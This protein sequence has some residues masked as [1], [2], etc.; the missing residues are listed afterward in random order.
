MSLA[1]RDPQDAPPTKA[2]NPDAQSTS[3]PSDI[4][5]ADL[6]RELQETNRLLRAIVSQKAVGLESLKVLPTLPT[7]PSPTAVGGGA[8][9]SPSPPELQATRAQARLLVETLA[10]AAFDPADREHLKLFREETIQLVTKT[11]ELRG[12]DGRDGFDIVPRSQVGVVLRLQDQLDHNIDSPSELL[13]SCRTHDAERNPRLTDHE[14]EQLRRQWPVYFDLDRLTQG[15]ARDSGWI[16]GNNPR[17][18]GVLCAS[19]LVVGPNH[20]LV[21]ASTILEP[22]QADALAV[23]RISSSN[24]VS[25]GSL[26]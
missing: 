4:S 19:P 10:R 7:V 6:A 20:D 15:I 12:H 16:L 23:S 11:P 1:P 2:L 5:V 21:P 24:L 25:P 8:I 26:W 9:P 14:M 3:L 18:S 22:S 17:R 13:W